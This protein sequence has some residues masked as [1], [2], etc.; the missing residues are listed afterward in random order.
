MRQ[1]IP[2]VYLMQNLR[3]SH[4]YLLASEHGLVLIDSG[5]AGEAEQI[6]AQLEEAGYSLSDLRTIL[7]THYHGDHIGNAAELARRSG[8]RVLAHR[9]D[10]PYIERTE[11]APAGSS[12]SR[13]LLTWMSERVFKTAPCKVDKALQDGD[14]VDTLGGLQ[15]IH[16]PGH[17]PG[18]IVFHQPE[19]RIL[20]CGDVLFNQSSLQLAPS[21]FSL[22]VPLAR[23]SA[24]KLAD[25]SVEVLCLGHGEPILENAQERIRVAVG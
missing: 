18:S 21:F 19:R 9:D 10:V 4:V 16:T 2:G 17:T 6:V 24:R 3:R 14:V 20:F 11:P 5:L 25:L 15:V 8:A 23:E 1:I 12:V 7:L 13:R 22:D